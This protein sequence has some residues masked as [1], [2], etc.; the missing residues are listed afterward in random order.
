MRMSNPVFQILLCWGLGWA[1]LGAQSP[2]PN[3]VII[4]ADDIGYGDLSCYQPSNRVKTPNVDKLAAQSLRFTKAYCTGAT[5]TPS[6]Y[7]L[8]TGEYAWRKN[9]TGI[10]PGDA[11][12]V[13]RS[14]RQTLGT[15]IQS[16]G[17]Q[18]A[19]VGK[20]HL[21]LGDDQGANWNGFIQ[22]SPQHIGFNY[23]FIMAATGDRVPT[24]YVEN[25]R[26]VNLDPKDPI[27]VSYKE[28][29]G[30]EPTGRENPELLKMG[31][32][33]GHDYTIVNGI[34]RIGYMS[35]GK[36]ARWVDEDMA[37]V[38]TQKAIQFIEKNRQT[39]FLLFFATQDI[40]V[41]R[42]P[43]A[44]F[45]GKSGMGPRGDALLEFDWSVG[46]ILE[47][48]QKNGLD[49]NTIVVLSS[50]NGPVIDDGYADQA[51]ALLKDHQPAGPFRGGK[52]SIFEAGTRVPF[53]LR[54]PQKVE[55]G[56]SNALISQVDFMASFAA[57]LGQKIDPIQA[58]D[59][60]NQWPALTGKDKKG[61]SHL[62]IHTQVGNM[63]AITDG[64]WKYIAPSD[65]KPFI[66]DTKTETGANPQA[67][68]YHLQK[69]PGERNNLAA[70]NPKKVV[71]FRRLLDSH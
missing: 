55:P 30:K 7:S 68:L 25:S 31:L 11:S 57:M 9:G 23:S 22:E 27:Q 5:C 2:K 50:D 35:G 58:P 32:T 45:V 43:H 15:L 40:H 1:S 42:A 39:P 12:A 66:K 17:Y 28:K 33:H 37:D 54:Y 13:I 41:P 16:A 61:R 59:S 70:Q 67:Q 10:L 63:K 36:Q 18:T 56:V 51:E 4:Y 52:Y 29:I 14:G 44:R 49:Q 62:I 65:A 69:D 64:T 24:V 21:G 6:R 3:V 20:W 71:R 38:F 19:V 53:L 60:Q 47:A 26:V 46:A 34:S 48:L 8:L